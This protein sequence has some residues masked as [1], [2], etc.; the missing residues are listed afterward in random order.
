MLWEIWSGPLSRSALFL[1]LV[2]SCAV[3]G[4]AQGVSAPPT[5]TPPSAKDVKVTKVFNAEGPPYDK[6]GLGNWIVVEVEPKV[7]KADNTQ[8]IPGF[9][10][11][12]DNKLVPYIDGLPL[13]GIYPEAIDG[14]LHELTYYLRRTADSDDT[15]YKLLKEPDSFSRKAVVSVGLE[16]ESPIATDVRASGQTFNLV[17]ITRGLFL[18]CLGII[19]G[20]VLILVLLASKSDILRSPGPRP[21]TGMSPYSLAYTQMAFWFCLVMSSFLIVWLI[22]GDFATIT[23]SVLGLIGISAGTAL[24]ATLIDV[25]K[26]GATNPPTLPQSRGFLR[27]IL[28]DDDGISLHRFQIFVWTIALGVIFCVEVYKNLSMPQFDPTLLALMGISAGTYLGFKFPEGQNSNGQTRTQ[29]PIAA[30][31]VSGNGQT[32]TEGQTLNVKDPGTGKMGITLDAARSQAGSSAIAA[33]EWTLTN[34][35]DGSLQTFSTIK[36]GVS[37]GT[38]TYDVTLK[39]TDGNGRSATVA[40]TIT[41]T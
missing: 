9:S 10:D 15:W 18:V 16:D 30:F 23:G 34:R 40:G 1:V 29:S 38:G 20:T 2:V 32:A 19:A 6:A 24:G 5:S 33:Y 37:L 26:Q 21:L 27:D 3:A 39:V 17:I 7:G 31:D 36:S 28:S 4:F 11:D 22:T 13:K 35:A 41:I 14:S 12:K 25:S 8:H